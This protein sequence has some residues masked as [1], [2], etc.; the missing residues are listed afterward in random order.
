[1]GK[2]ASDGT[3]IFDTR[4]DEKGLLDGLRQIEKKPLKVQ[5]SKQNNP[6]AGLEKQKIK[7]E[8]QIADL[9]SKIDELY[10]KRAVTAKGA[11]V[12]GMSDADNQGLIESNKEW[13]K[14]TAL[15]ENAERQLEAYQEEHNELLA[16]MKQE[17]AAAAQSNTEISAATAQKRRE[18]ETY[19]GTLEGLEQEQRE[20]GY[21]AVAAGEEDKLAKMSSKQMAEAYRDSMR[22]LSLE[23][24]ETAQSVKRIGK[25][26]RDGFGTATKSA[27][28]FQ[29]RL[30]GIIG[31]ALIFSQVYKVIHALMDFMGSAAA[32]N[33]EFTQSLKS[34]KANLLTAFA[35][36]YNTVMP[37]I[38][39][40]LKGLEKITQGLAKITAQLFGWTVEDAQ[41]A[42]DSIYS[43]VNATE[44]YTEAVKEAERTQAGFDELH[45]LQE[46]SSSSASSSSGNSS[47]EDNGLIF[48]DA[49]EFKVPA[50][51]ET[52]WEITCKVFNAAGKA[53]EWA[54]GKGNSIYRFITG[55]D[56]DYGT[57]Q[58]QLGVVIETIFS[59]EWKDALKL[60][61][62]DIDEAWNELFG[63]KI[64]DLFESFTSGEWKEALE[65]WGQDIK[66]AWNEIL[67]LFEQSDFT[68]NNDDVGEKGKGLAG[69]NPGER[70]AEDV[71]NGYKS[72]MA[73]QQST[74]WTA[75]VNALRSLGLVDSDPATESETA[76]ESLADKMKSGFVDKLNKGKQLVSDIVKGIFGKKDEAETAAEQ[77]GS[78]AADAVG[79][80]FASKKELLNNKLELALN[81]TFAAAKAGSAANATNC[82]ESLTSSVGQGITGQQASLTSKLKL[83]LQNAFGTAKADGRLDAAACGTALTTPLGDGFYNKRGNITSKIKDAL[84]SAADA[85]KKE[86]SGGSIWS[87]LQNIGANVVEGIKNGLGSKEG[88]LLDS[89]GS[90][91]SKMIDK[92]TKVLGIHS[93]SKAFYEKA[94]WITPGID[95]A[96]LDGED[97]TMRIIQN[98]ARSLPEAWTTPV[99]ATGT[100]LPARQSLGSGSGADNERIEQMLSQALGLLR[101]ISTGKIVDV[102]LIGDTRNMFQ[103]FLEERNRQ[104]DITGIDPI[105]GEL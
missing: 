81:S 102:N 70:Y 63:Y 9:D 17:Q 1:M 30:R 92:F 18:T 16:K 57:M 3:L 79:V 90:I 58:E 5:T 61:G 12:P 45:N 76:G 59:G 66:D 19:R 48:K 44:D 93:P 96:I 78:A 27:G 34:I 103:L 31:S 37:F 2:S 104:Q 89:I 21:T 100:V 7:L 95:N 10:E 74:L 62:Q 29:K 28:H 8:Q 105:L 25:A 49:S 39:W 71:A 13:Q 98:Y 101:K 35:P 36:I 87:S 33:D 40:L 68:G 75:T 86:S 97:E 69:K 22:R 55:D 32:Q 85:A 99:F 80:G 91:G 65:L 46:S 24:E 26:A 88:T 43:A 11:I 6:F 15:I 60:W 52:V 94:E 42:A 77:T 64:S 38:N 67:S 20:L 23:Q 82:G 84:K 83:A 41:K 72:G 14:Q 4:I 50:V 53:V 56:T 73:S 54:Y 47:S 51:L